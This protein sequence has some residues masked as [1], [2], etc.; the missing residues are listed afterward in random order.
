MLLR[1]TS[2][3]TIEIEN[4]EDE[5]YVVSE[6]KG[7]TEKKSLEDAKELAIAVDIGT[8][9]IAMQLDRSGQRGCCR[10]IYNDQ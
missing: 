5:I 9:T 8:T 2:N 6:S 4:K 3:C 7:E 1:L 10:N